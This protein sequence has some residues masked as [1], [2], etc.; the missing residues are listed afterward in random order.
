MSDRKRPIP[1][2]TLAELKKQIDDL[3]ELQH[4]ALDRATHLGMTTDEAKVV[5]GRRKQ[6]GKLVDQLAQLKSKA[7]PSTPADDDS[8]SQ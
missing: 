3:L 6:I 7:K 5:E 2:V 4:Q 1:E 8:P